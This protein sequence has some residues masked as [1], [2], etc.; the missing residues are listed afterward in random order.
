MSKKILVAGDVCLDVIGVPKPRLSKE[1][2]SL[3]NW[4]LTGEIRTHYLRGGALLLADM[5]R[6]AVPKAKV[7]G[8]ELNTPPALRSKNTPRKLDES[9]F[10]RLT[11]EEIVYSVIRAE[12]FKT[13]GKADKNDLT[14]RVA[15]TLGFSGPATGNPKLTPKVVA[16]PDADVLV[17]DDTGNRFRADTA[18]WENLLAANPKLIV[19]KLHRPLPLK[20][21][22]AKSLWGELA[23]NHG[24]RT[25]VVVSADDLRL[26][27]AVA[28]RQ[29]SWERTARELL[30]NLIGAIAFKP[31][32]EC[33]WLVVRFGL[34]G[35]LCWHHP[36]SA[37]A[38]NGQA[39]LIYDPAG[40]EN[41][42]AP[43][44]AGGMVGYGSAFTAAL[45]AAL[46]NSATVLPGTATEI[47]AALASGIKQGL[48]AARLLLK[49]GLGKVDGMVEPIYPSATIFQEAAQ[50]EGLF[51]C[52]QVP[53]PAQKTVADPTGDWTI[54]QKLLPGGEALRNAAI[55]LA[56]NKKA[57][58]ALAGVPLGEFGKL[59][60][61][62][63]G[64]IESYRAVSNLMRE[65]LAA[66]TAK[67]PL[68]FAV[69]GPP[70]SGKSFGVEQV[71]NAV[72]G[73]AFKLKKLVFNLS[74]FQSP[75]ELTPAFHLVRDAV[76]K[77]NVPLVFFD[78]FDSSVGEARLFWLKYL[79][80]PM[81][82]GE[83]LEQGTVHPI[84]KAIFVFAGGTSDSYEKFVRPVVAADDARAADI[85]FRSVKGKDFISRL[86][87]YL[88][89]SGIDH[90]EGY[91]GPGLL[92]RAGIL[93]FQLQEKAPHLFS[94][95]GTLHI[96]HGVLRA[97]LEL[98]KYE[99]GV[100]SLEAVLDMSMLAGRERFDPGCLPSPQQLSLHAPPMQ[101]DQPGLGFLELVHAES[102]W[103]ATVREKIARAIHEHYLD[104]RKSKKELNPKKES[105]QEWDHPLN[106]FYKDSNRA[107]ADDIPRKLRLL[108]LDFL[109][110]AENKKTTVIAEND[111]KDARF[112]P[113]IDFA[114]CSEH[115]RW[116]AERRRQGWIF[117]AKEDVSARI[118]PDLVDWKKL[119]AK[120][121]EKDI[122]A[123]RAIPRYLAA[124]GYVVIPK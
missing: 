23:K 9:L 73:D 89:I 110:A 63:R 55:D 30:W 33:R 17:L 80:A 10:E 42:F 29:L 31:L 47:P 35:A 3:E 111:L 66:P 2:D 74:Q 19:H 51:G 107:Q 98:K 76:L 27:G 49:F 67:R 58:K 121:Q 12:M 95:D 78:E 61:Y 79:L 86:R 75:D 48:H 60:T 101:T 91:C 11:R 20:P 94:A 52:V 59:K 5:V 104:E 90:G 106:D 36:E 38:G 99:H 88:N 83:F 22:N 124:A 96:D 103:P 102:P 97:F 82:D 123:I 120:T 39:W 50:S 14:L 57:P 43:N 85:F 112:A 68:C 1:D 26:A 69:F 122:A 62:D 117:G 84:G 77:G 44:I 56:L 13:G 24:D 70:G 109:P 114:A 6:E 54:L 72:A 4:R 71:A 81:Q 45:T 40:I 34:D 113:Q 87:G 25:V 8:P 53:L 119:D 64:E 100:R 118:H 65:Y 116:C 32:A 46:C 41:G 37:E 93:R 7:H 28:G 15:Q 115:E 92:R 108:G 16:V 18:Q 105:H 21:D